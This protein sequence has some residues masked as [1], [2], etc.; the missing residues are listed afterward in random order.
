MIHAIRIQ[1]ATGSH[2]SLRI[3]VG[4]NYA[5]ATWT[6][7]DRVVES[8]VLSIQGA[9]EAWRKFQLVKRTQGKTNTFRQNFEL[10]APEKY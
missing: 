4:S 1:T 7:D 3:R 5:F 2:F 10:T 9:R 8:R 6:L